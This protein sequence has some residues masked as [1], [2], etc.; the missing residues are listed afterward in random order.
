MTGSKTNPSYVK[1]VIATSGYWMTGYDR[2]FSNVALRKKIPIGI[3]KNK[4]I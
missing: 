4:Y 1:A 3:V 2:F